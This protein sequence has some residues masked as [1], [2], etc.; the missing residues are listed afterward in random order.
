[1]PVTVTDPNGITTTLHYDGLGRLTGVWGYSRPTTSPG[2]R[3]LQLRRVQQRPDRGDHPEAQRRVR[4][5]HLHHAVST[6]CCGSARPRSPPRRAGSWSPTTSTTPA[7]GSGR[8]TPTG[9]TPA[10]APG[11]V[12]SSRPR[13][14][15]ARP[16]RH[17]LRRAG[18]AGAGHVLRRL[19]G[20]VDH[21]HRLLRRPGH[22]RPRLGRHPD[23]DGDRRA[24]PDHRAGLLHLAADGDHQHRQRH[25]H[26]DDH[27]RHHPGHRLRLQHPRRAVGHHRSGHRR[28]TGPDTT[29]CSARTPA[30]P[31]P[32]SGTTR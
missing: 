24:G 27:R 31:T 25:H 7:A 12:R 15:G 16:D 10:P 4:V 2:E 1:M 19:A 6:R 28:A 5:H 14:P 20:Q 23:L 9:G 13:Q 17:R 3:H 21:R 26:G 18:P 8:S 29:T 22:H 11:S 30:R 32:N